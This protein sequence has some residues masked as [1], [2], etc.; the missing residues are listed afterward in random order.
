MLYIIYNVLEFM[1]QAYCQV[2]ANNKGNNLKT[3]LQTQVKNSAY[4][5]LTL[6]LTHVKK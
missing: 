2:F 4:I 1:F 6:K 5:Y 3:Y